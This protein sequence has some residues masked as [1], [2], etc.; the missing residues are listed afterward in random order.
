MLLR[1]DLLGNQHQRQAESQLKFDEEIME[2][3]KSYD[4]LGSL[5]AA[6]EECGCSHNTV[7]SYVRK[8][9]QGLLG[10]PLKR[11]RPSIVDPY[12]PKIEEWVR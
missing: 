4:R 1:L 10:E 2:I 6:A 7:G 11:S 5:R 3:L 12:R 9:A 8:R